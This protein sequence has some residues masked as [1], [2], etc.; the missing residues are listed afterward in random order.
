MYVSMIQVIR[1]DAGSREGSHPLSER[2]IPHDLSNAR[3]EVVGKAIANPFIRAFQANPGQLPVVPCRC[4]PGLQ[5][6]PIR[7]D[8]SSNLSGRPE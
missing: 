2:Q 1:G 4:A 5:L 6:R 3:H 8:T 7:R